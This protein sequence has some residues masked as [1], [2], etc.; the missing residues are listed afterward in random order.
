MGQ[1]D[2]LYDLLDLLRSRRDGVGIR[3]MCD[4]L[5]CSVPT[6]KRAI[7]KLRSDF[8]APVRYD[9]GCNGYVIDRDD[10]VQLPGLWFN[11]SELHSLLIIH[12]LLEQLEPGL[13][14]T[15]LTPMRQRVECLLK[16]RD[17]QTG[18]LVRRI[19]FVGVGVRP[20]CPLHFKV[21]ARATMERR[22]LRL[23]YLSREK[24]RLSRRTVSPQRML[25]YRGNWY[26]AVWCHTRKGLRILALDR[27]KELVPLDKPCQE[28]ADEVLDTHLG[29]SFGIFSGTARYQAVLRFTAERARWV[30]EETWHPNQQG[31]WLENGEYEL[32]LPYSDARELVLEILKYGPDVEVLAP[33]ELRQEVQR[34]LTATLALYRA[35]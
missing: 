1:A 9:A 7:A 11:I 25:Y 6:V 14:K 8:G 31:R 16:G 27:I 12:E 4:E 10:S 33:D 30:A 35:E 19:K 26:L 18:D 23:R 29:E 17:M 15:E 34:R 13:L 20:C 2:R 3:Q 24:N 32:T 22:Q 21:V 28:I 5:E